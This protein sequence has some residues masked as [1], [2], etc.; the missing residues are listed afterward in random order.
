MR[1]TKPESRQSALGRGRRGFGGEL[2]QR[3][4]GDAEQ[5]GCHRDPPG[6]SP[7]WGHQAQDTPSASCQLHKPHAATATAPRIV[8][9][10]SWAIGC[11]PE[12]LLRH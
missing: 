11:C 10:V 1:L 3:W 12:R 6:L 5:S 2:E 9:S 4:F 7:A 8:K